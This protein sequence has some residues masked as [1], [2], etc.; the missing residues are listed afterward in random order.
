MEAVQPCPAIKATNISFCSVALL[1]ILIIY[2]RIGW[3]GSIVM[4]DH[5]LSRLRRSIQGVGVGSGDDHRSGG[6]AEADGC[7]LVERSGQPET[8]RGGHGWHDA[9][10]QLVPQ[11]ALPPVSIAVVDGLPGSVPLGNIP[12]G[13]TCVQLPEDPVEH[14]SMVFPW[15]PAIRRVLRQV[16]FKDLP[17]NICQFVPFRIH[18][19]L[20]LIA[21]SVPPY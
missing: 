6:V 19:Y 11:T 15:S 14:L 5:C 17:L 8:A 9:A 21:S 3:N 10:H 18:L 1:L 12:P 7:R 2:N 20:S 13:S 16:R 4:C